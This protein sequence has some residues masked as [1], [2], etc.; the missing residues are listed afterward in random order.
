MEQIK[1]PADIRGQWIWDKTLSGRD[2]VF[3]L[4]SRSFE[5][6]QPGLDNLL[7]IGSKGAYQLFI[8]ERFVGFGPHGKTSGDVACLDCH[9]IGRYL[10]SGQNTVAVIVH[11]TR[12]LNWEQGG[13]GCQLE[14]D[15]D[16]VMCSDTSWHVMEGKA[17]EFPSPRASDGLRSE[18]VDKNLLPAG[19][20]SSSFR[21]TSEWRRADIVD[22]ATSFD[23]YPLRPP[24]ADMLVDFQ[25]VKRGVWRE[26]CDWTQ[27]DFGECRGNY[28]AASVAVSYLYCEEPDNLAVRIFSDDRYRLFCNRK[29]VSEAVSSL[30]GVCTL[31]LQKGWNR[32]TVFQTPGNNSPGFFIL[33]PERERGSVKFFCRQDESSQSGWLIAGPLKMPIDFATDSL[34]MENLDYQSY[35]PAENQ[36]IDMAAIF[37]FAEFKPCG[38]ADFPL[39]LGGGEFFTAALD[40]LRYG[41]PVVEIEA[42][43]GDVIDLIFDA[44]DG[45]SSPENCRRAVHTLCCRKGLNRFTLFH[46]RMGLFLNLAVRRASGRVTVLNCHLEE[47]LRETSAETVFR[48][49]DETL[50][51]LWSTGVQTLRRSAAFIPPLEHDTGCNAY[52]LD[53]YIDAVNMVA[54]FGDRRYSAAR[55]RQF[56]DGQF[57]NGDIPVLAFD[58]APRSQAHQLFFLPVWALYNYRTSG[59]L[60]ELKSL[61]N[62]LMRLWDF[63]H[64]LEDEETGLLGNLSDYFE[65][66]SRLFLRSFGDT[67]FPTSTNAL[68]CRFLLAMAEILRIAGHGNSGERALEQVQHIA[69]KLRSCN[70][71][72]S[73]RLFRHST[74]AGADTADFWLFPNFAALF[75]GVMGLDDF[76]G[77]FQAF[78]NMETPFDRSGEAASPYF[79]FLFMET[80][81]ALGK[82]EWAAAYLREYWQSRLNSSAGAWLGG[83]SFEPELLC[84]GNIVSPNVFLVREIA[85]VRSADAGHSAIYFHPAL[86]QA[87]WVDLI[88]PTASGKLH[89]RWEN[90][91]DG[92]LHVLIDSYYPIKVLPEFSDE[93]LKNTVFELSENVTLLKR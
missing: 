5:I 33:F 40:T 80:V 51:T 10:Q 8:N 4:L 11:Y 19:W 28:T 17:F 72:E 36:P 46:P 7:W 30:G 1:L 15:G 82:S 61:L 52:V 25:Q 68:Y 29:C 83:E 21:Y 27:V 3:L 57:E 22:I 58:S 49:S 50:N 13:F 12:F 9:E 18:Y 44:G 87:K 37:S 92:T 67:G 79:N 53:A 6:I 88:L 35:N 78:F 85:G 39:H 16:M 43:Q 76:E 69:A 65:V 74:S 26:V 42:S 66:E 48:S 75:G 34:H 14:I 24:A 31:A 64:S 2:N 63:Y 73:N 32:V 60:A 45:F 59:D 38:D 20:T 23:V 41:V 71:D 77:F 62:P 90:M 86:E 91:D 93:Q 70:F 47:L 54:A 81:F 84:N 55:L 89:I 56:V